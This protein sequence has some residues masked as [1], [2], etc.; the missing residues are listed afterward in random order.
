ML[1][2]HIQY[3]FVC[4]CT[5]AYFLF[6][7]PIITCI[8]DTMDNRM[9]PSVV[10]YEGHIKCIFLNPK[11]ISY[12]ILFNAVAHP[13]GLNCCYIS[14][15]FKTFSQFVYF[16]NFMIMAQ[17]AEQQLRPYP[18]SWQTAKTTAIL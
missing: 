2:V 15:A 10:Y 4:E 12:T 13:M 1:Y 7:Q 11:S 18:F 14:E 9:L 3:A 6:F 8:L 17:E 5:C 16:S